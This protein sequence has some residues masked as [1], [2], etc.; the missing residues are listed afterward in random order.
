[1]G[2]EV[3]PKG[4]QQQTGQTQGNQGQPAA[5]T[6]QPVEVEVEPGKKVTLDELKKGYMMDADYRRKTAEVAEQRRQLEA[7]KQRLAQERSRPA[8]QPQIRSPFDT[9]TDGDDEGPN[10]IQIL[11]DELARTKAGLAHIVLSS[12]IGRLSPTYAEADP[13]TVY[14]ICW[15]N[16][17]GTNIEDEMRKSHEKA[18][19][20]IS[21][22]KE[23]VKP[24][25]NLSLDEFL[26]ANPAAKAEYDKR[27]T[28]AVDETLARKR[29]STGVVSGGAGSGQTF[30]EPEEKPVS[31]RDATKK[32]RERLAE[33]EKSPI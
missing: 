26:T 14:Q 3:D 21:R 22:V 10:P 17:H 15:A 25:Q 32:L 18:V 16:P 30:S 2:T 12:E 8:P 27:K 11:A 4:N 19:A 24:Q 28:T 33:S 1:M 20:K 9:G 5:G 13:E 23:E 7:E 29:Q 6:T 31:Y